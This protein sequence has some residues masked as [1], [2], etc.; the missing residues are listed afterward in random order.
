MVSQNLASDVQRTVGSNEINCNVPSQRASR[1]V[2]TDVSAS[3]LSSDR[4]EFVLPCPLHFSSDS[5][6]L[7]VEA[8]PVTLIF[9]LPTMKKTSAMQTKS[10]SCLCS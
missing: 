9:L 6:H 7:G 10:K 4:N 1:Y 3:L 2:G 5:D 8:Q